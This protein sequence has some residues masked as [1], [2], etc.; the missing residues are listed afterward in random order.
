MTDEE[1]ESMEIDWTQGVAENFERVKSAA[2]AALDA[3]N[4]RADEAE[5]KLQHSDTGVKNLIARAESAEAELTKVTDPNAVHVNMLRGTIAKPSVAQI[6]HLYGDAI[7]DPAELTRLREENEQYRESTLDA[8]NRRVAEL[9]ARRK[10]YE[11]GSEM[12]AEELEE[13][14]KR[15]AELDNLPDERI[16]PS[17]RDRRTLLSA[18]EAANRRADEAEA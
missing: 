5:Q 16:W 3:A 18:L 10:C 13:I 15:E 12:T 6:K 17:A 14:R 7:A 8:A 1:L 4:R 2:L 11:C 9:E